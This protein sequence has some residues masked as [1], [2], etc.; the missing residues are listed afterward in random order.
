MCHD[1]HVL[2]AKKK[3]SGRALKGREVETELFWCYIKSN[4]KKT[5]ARLFVRGL[6]VRAIV[7]ECESARWWGTSVR[8][9]GLH[10]AACK[11]RLSGRVFESTHVGV[12]DLISHP[13]YA[14]R[15]PRPRHSLMRLAKLQR[16][17]EKKITAW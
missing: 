2:V 14:T 16:E 7:E 10:L 4:K 8:P 1:C 13:T 3:E 15:I 11:P 5:R 9:K 12:Q 17:R 6:R